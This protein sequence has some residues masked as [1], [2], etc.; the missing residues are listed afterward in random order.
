MVTDVCGTWVRGD[1][2]LLFQSGSSQGVFGRTCHDVCYSHLLGDA[3]GAWAWAWE[4]GCW[5][6]RVAILSLRPRGGEC[7]GGFVM[8]GS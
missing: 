6:M 3:V 2:R 7:A 5:M 1:R 8:G 4:G